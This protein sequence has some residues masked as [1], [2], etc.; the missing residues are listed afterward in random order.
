MIARMG[1]DIVSYADLQRWPEDGHQYELYDG[2]VRVVPSATN[3]HQLV[4]QQL[5]VELLA[6]QRAHGGRILT[7]PSDVVFNQY[8]VLQPDLLYFTQAR[9]HLV[10]LDKPTDV[11]PDLAIEILSPSTATHDRTRKHA[12]YARFGVRELW[13]VDPTE[14]TIEIFA[15]DGRNYR[16]A[17]MAGLSDV[18][19]TSPTINSL[20]VNVSRVFDIG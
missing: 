1:M 9:R 3:R 5:F 14:E 2:E 12:M 7:A 10:Q 16:R 15:L 18:A 17:S 4:A 13:I 11:A 20:A 8:N 19:T 6:F